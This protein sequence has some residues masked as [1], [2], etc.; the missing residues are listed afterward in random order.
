MKVKG[1][2]V[3]PFSRLTNEVEQVRSSEFF[4]SVGLVGGKVFVE[5]IELVETSLG[6]LGVGK[7]GEKLATLA[8]SVIVHEIV[9]PLLD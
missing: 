2:E 3:V 9:E 6:N 7:S 1:K 8:K 4:E 5:R